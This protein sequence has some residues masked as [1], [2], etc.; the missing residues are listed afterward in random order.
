MVACFSL[1]NSAQC[2]GL[3]QKPKKIMGKS[4]KPH[5]HMKPHKSINS[6]IIILLE[7]STTFELSRYFNLFENSRFIKKECGL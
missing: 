2:H 1:H 6:N 4:D 3:Y 5:K 7:I